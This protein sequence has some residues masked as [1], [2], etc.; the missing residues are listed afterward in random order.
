VER[1][2]RFAAGI[3]KTGLRLCGG[4]AFGKQ[5]QERS[6]VVIDPANFVVVRGRARAAVPR[7]ASAAWCGASPPN[8]A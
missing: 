6:G 2:A 7:G 4:C 8:W 5:V 1:Q 3:D